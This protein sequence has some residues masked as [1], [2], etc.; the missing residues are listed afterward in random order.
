[1]MKKFVFDGLS[2]AK[3][4]ID[5]H[6]VDENNVNEHIMQ[7]AKYNFYVNKMNDTENYSAIVEYLRKHWKAFAESDYEKKIED[8]VKNAQKYPFKSIESIKITRKELDFIA[9][10]N[11]IR[12]EKIA[13][14][15][16]C[17]A[18][19]ECYYHDEPKYWIA[20]SLNNISKLARVHVTKDENRKL[21]RELVVT[22]VIE[23]NSS[24]GNLYEHILFVSNDVND[25][26][27]LELSE[28]DYKEL[29]YTY[30]FYKNGFSGYVHCDKCGRLVKQKSNRQ[31]FCNECAE[32]VQQEN[33]RNRVRKY[34]CKCNDL[35]PTV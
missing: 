16:L 28:V 8:Y 27:V 11:N 1:M 12:L 20:W 19:Y 33:A 6:T 25:E 3:S 23:S 24:A 32:L 10:L 13:F 4:V 30:L 22:G 21:F 18:K 9:N 26:V 31:K 5:D 35:E 2:Y 34:R 17:I 7:L 14:V 15:L 29:A